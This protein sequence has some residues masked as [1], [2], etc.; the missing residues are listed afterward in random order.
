MATPHVEALQRM[1]QVFG[2]REQHLLWQLSWY[3]E[4]ENVTFDATF[5][6]REP[7]L[8]VTLDRD[9]AREFLA[10]LGGRGGRAA[11]LLTRVAFSDGTAVSVDR[12]WTINYMPR[13]LDLTAIDLAQGETCRRW[14]RD[15]SRNNSRHL[16]L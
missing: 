2:S 6:D 12:I 8:E 5:Y 10:S 14:R 4:H 1:R 15:S 9:F 16:S 13:E 7:I 3:A 11:E